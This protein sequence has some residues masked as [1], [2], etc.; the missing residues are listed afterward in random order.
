MPPRRQRN[1]LALF[2]LDEYVI[3]L[4]RV[5]KKTV[6][7]LKTVASEPLLIQRDGTLLLSLFR[8]TVYSVPLR[9]HILLFP[10]LSP[11]RLMSRD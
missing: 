3:T 1:F 8:C 4:G 5:L 7:I 2:C 11:V 9:T 10:E 6:S